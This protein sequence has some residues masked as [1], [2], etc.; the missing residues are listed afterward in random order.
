MASAAQLG[1]NAT[2]AGLSSGSDAARKYYLQKLEGFDPAAAFKQ[3]ETG[4][5]GDLKTTLGR[6]L[7]DLA[8]SEAG[9]GRLNTGYYALDT[10]DLIDRVSQDYANRMLS[11]ALDVNNQQLGAMGQAANYSLGAGATAGEMQSAQLDRE[12]A[13]KNAAAKRRAGLWGALG[14]AAGGVGGFLL[15]GPAGAELGAQLGGQLGYGVA[16]Y[17]G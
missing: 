14:T 11:G 5:L 8:G 15:G 1:Y 13:A 6:N 12:L 3:Y 16:G 17:G 7:Q 2:T 4:A 10:G 9:S